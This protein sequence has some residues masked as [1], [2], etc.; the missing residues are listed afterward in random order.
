MFVEHENMTL[1]ERIHGYVERN[2]T[3][4]ARA[5]AMVGDYLEECWQWEIDFG[6]AAPLT[7]SH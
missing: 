3:E 7:R 6:G 2:Q 5:L 1:V 4:K